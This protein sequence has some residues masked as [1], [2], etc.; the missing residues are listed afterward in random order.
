MSKIKKNI[1]DI[2]KG[3]FLISK[4]S[5]KNWRFLVFIVILMLLMISSAHYADRQ[6]LEIA[7]LNKEI[8]ELKAEFVDTRSVAMKIKLES[9]IKNK[10]KELG[11]EPSENPPEI[12][13]VTSKSIK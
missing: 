4:N 6:V 3:N 1:Y 2:L 7:K 9:N 5:L 13:K 10:V 12:I 8:K 11:L